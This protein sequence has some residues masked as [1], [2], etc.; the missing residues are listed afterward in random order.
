MIIRTLK[1]L[2]AIVLISSLSGCTP[3]I[4]DDA[5]PQIP[6]D[7]IVLELTLPSN[8]PLA[9]NGGTIYIG[10]GVRGILVYRE[11]ESRY[12]AFERNCSYHPNDA[13]ATVNVDQTKLF[14]VDP[15]CQSRFRFPDGT[16]T[17]GPAIRPLNRYVTDLDG[18]TLT[19]RSTVY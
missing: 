10:G 18:T 17:D 15:C 14:M 12:I 6:F 3:D 13:C 2:F 8:Q 19:I 5:I 9:T 16:P 7:D 4:S 11:N 1:S